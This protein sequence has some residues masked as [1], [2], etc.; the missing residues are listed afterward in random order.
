MII[1]LVL[2]LPPVFAMLGDNTKG[3]LRP[4][5]LPQSGGADNRLGLEKIEDQVRREQEW[6]PGVMY[7]ESEP[8]K[9]LRKLL[10]NDD[11]NFLAVCDLLK[12]QGGGEWMA[13]R[14]EALKG[15]TLDFVIDTSLSMNTMDGMRSPDGKY[16]M[17]RMDELK[18]RLDII[19]RFI[20]YFPIK[21]VIVRDFERLRF[22]LVVN[23]DRRPAQEIYRELRTHLD[24]VSA[25]Y[26]PVDFFS[27]GTPLKAAFDAVFETGYS[28]D[29]RTFLYIASDGQPTDCEPDALQHIVSSRDAE[30]YPLCFLPCTNE[31]N[32]ISWMNMLDK[33]KNV[34]VVDDPESEKE[35]IFKMQGVSFP[36]TSSFLLLSSLLGGI[37]PFFDRADEKY[38]YSKEEL[39]EVVGYALSDD[40]YARYQ[41]DAWKRQNCSCIIL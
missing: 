30:R 36:V 37:D 21:K 41:S 25:N 32:N 22:P 31:E 33:E 12:S 23:F 38:I 1:A 34:H 9:R 14:M 17:S 28:C 29:D 39:E 20:S 11:G 5:S 3:M 19:F 13:Y 27:G 18:T 16:S 24:S 2:V 4:R 26:Q 15:A 35:E 10:G 40:S 6:P 8:V 7:L